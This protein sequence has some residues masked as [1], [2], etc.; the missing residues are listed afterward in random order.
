MENNEKVNLLKRG[1]VKKTLIGVGGFIVGLVVY[2]LLSKDKDAKT[3]NCVELTGCTY[4][5]GT[6][7][8]EGN[9]SNEE[10]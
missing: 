3:V 1:W 2:G 5:D 7:L 4:E 8:L 10:G 6:T 9:N